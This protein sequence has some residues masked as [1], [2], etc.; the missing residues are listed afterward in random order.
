MALVDCGRPATAESNRSAGVVYLGMFL[1]YLTFLWNITRSSRTSG[2][3]Y[4]PGICPLLYAGTLGASMNQHAMTSE[5]EEFI[6]R[7]NR[8]HAHSWLR[9]V[10]WSENERSLVLQIAEPPSGRFL[11]DPRLALG[12]VIPA[13]QSHQA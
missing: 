6:S 9:E 10:T 3:L 13:I 12:N 2:H 11:L 8:S 4:V 1:L 5:I 7:E